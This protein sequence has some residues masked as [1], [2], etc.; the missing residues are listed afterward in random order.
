MAINSEANRT[1][2]V[3]DLVEIFK[4]LVGRLEGYTY[5]DVSIY[6]RPRSGSSN[7]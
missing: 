6:I 3:L 7:R 4:F 2:Y 5:A 1:S